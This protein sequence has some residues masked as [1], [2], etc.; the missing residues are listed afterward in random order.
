MLALLAAS[1]A[2][3]AA[4]ALLLGLI[5]GSFLN[6]VIYRLPIMLERQWRAEC[7][8]LAEAASELDAAPSAG[9]AAAVQATRLGDANP[10]PPSEPRFNLAV[11]RSV[12]PSCRAPIKAIHNIPILSYLALRGRCANCK[13]HIS[14]RYP[15]VE[16][17]CGLATAAVALR[18]GVHFPA[19]C[20]ALVTW[21]LLALAMIDLDTQLLPDSMTLPLLWGGI[22]ASLSGWTLPGFALPVDPRSA[23]LGAAAGY[24]FLWSVYHVFRLATGKEGM[25]YGDFKLLGALGA[26][27]GWQML[28]PIVLLSA[29]V[30]A[31][32][33]GA[34]ILSRRTQRGNPMPFGPF[35][36]AAGWIAMMWGPQLVARYLG[37]YAHPG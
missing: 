18:F 29:L 12:C 5:V 14:L 28:L 7:A 11:P 36:A 34:L 27:L 20:A 15:A 8:E 30:G 16:L 24:L 33:G 26:W 6:V 23:I 4:V 1:P 10:S 17:A 22:L 3:F 13:T 37:L 31:L 25:G 9:T 32:V 35:L 2:A 21:F 19:A